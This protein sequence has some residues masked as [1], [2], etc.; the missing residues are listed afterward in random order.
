[1]REREMNPSEFENSKTPE[2]AEVEAAAWLD[3]LQGKLKL[4]NANQKVHLEQ[5]GKGFKGDH[6]VKMVEET[7]AMLNLL[8]LDFPED[9]DETEQLMDFLKSKEMLEKAKT[10]VAMDTFRKGDEIK[11]DEYE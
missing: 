10:A 5:G 11:D 4:I 9:S 7:K 1:M 2:N 3:S 6:Y 8:D